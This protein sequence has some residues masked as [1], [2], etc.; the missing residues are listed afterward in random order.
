MLK[1]GKCEA[2]TSR[3][4]IYGYDIPC[5]T[6]FNYWHASM[7]NIVLHD[8]FAVKMHCVS[9]LSGNLDQILVTCRIA[10]D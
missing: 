8:F 10:I 7:G 1:T 4:K 5:R 3:R 6:Y 2:T 9:D